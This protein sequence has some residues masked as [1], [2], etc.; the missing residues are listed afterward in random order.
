MINEFEKNYVSDV[1]SNI[2]E[3][4]STTRYS[5]WASV[6]KY[7]LELEKNVPNINLNKKLNF[8]DFG[9]GNGKYLSFGKK[10]NTFALDNCEELLQIVSKSYPNIHIIK[11]DVSDNL[12]N[13]NLQSDYFDS[14]ISVAVIHH[15][16]TEIRR[17]KMI[18]NIY[19]L[20]K[21]NGTCLIT[22]WA[23]SFI[24]ANTAKSKSTLTKLDESND[25][26]ISW[27]NQFQ[28]YYHLFESDELEELIRKAEL[29]KNFLI[30]LVS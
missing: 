3:H 2:A 6:K 14:I 8:L 11:G 4:F 13:M 20:L 29:D 9:C 16:S 28:R 19:N 15:L 23:N 12:N 18:Q 10:F 5:H 22:V 25:Y 26:L 7:L 30:D 17:I 21:P 1:Y 27:N 24:N